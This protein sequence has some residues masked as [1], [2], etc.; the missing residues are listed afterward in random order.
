MFYDIAKRLMDIIGS[1]LA[2]II[3]SPILLLV[4]IAIKFDSVGPIFADTPNRVGQDG[5][6]FRMYKFRSMVQNAHELLEKNPQ[7][8]KE[9]K[10]NGYKIFKDPRITRVGRFIRRFSIDE[11]PQFLNILRGE[12]GIV[13][14]RA[15][16]AFELEDQQKKY[17]QTQ[18]YVK[19]ILAGKPGLTG[20]WQ[21]S[22]RSNINFDKRVEMDAL[23]LQRRSLLYDIWIILKTVPAVLLGRGAV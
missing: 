15:Y 18:K 17:P 10:K 16:Y 13:G 23:Y 9:Y 3:L 2:L 11:F 6:L 7:L 5:K 12:M 1:L 21:V 20:V 19:L 14:P 4:S 8:M 22:G